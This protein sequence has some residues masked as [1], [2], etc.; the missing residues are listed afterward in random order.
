MVS[1][2]YLFID[3]FIH[4]LSS[5][6]LWGSARQHLRIYSFINSLTH[7]TTIEWFKIWLPLARYGLEYKIILFG[8]TGVFLSVPKHDWC[9][10]LSHPSIHFCMLVNHGPSQQSSKEE[11]KP[12]K[13]GAT[14][15]YYAS[16]T[17]YYQR[18]SP[19]QDPASNRTTRRPPDHRK[20][21]QTALVWSCL[22]KTI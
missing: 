18:G 9:S 17:P 11:Y 22:A 20:E 15:R 6:S 14:A 8:M 13:S 10:P 5:T 16:H 4:N 21:T 1:L 3:P 19:R 12:W 2:Y 7:T